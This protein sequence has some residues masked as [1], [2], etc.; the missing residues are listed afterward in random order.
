MSCRSTPRLPPLSIITPAGRLLRRTGQSDPWVVRPAA[1]PFGCCRPA[2]GSWQ[3][4]IAV[5]VA[6]G[7]LASGDQLLTRRIDPIPNPGYWARA[8]CE[9]ISLSR[10]GTI[11]HMGRA[12]TPGAG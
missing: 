11:T 9:A 4:E 6:C 8:I 2:F 7:G 5:V 12:G 3:L 1:V 10:A